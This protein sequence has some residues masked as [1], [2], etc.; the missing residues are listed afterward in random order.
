MCIYP[1]IYRCKYCGYTMQFES[2]YKYDI[3]KDMDFNTAPDIEL[4]LCHTPDWEELTPEE[5][6]HGKDR[7]DETH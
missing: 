7:L 3:L 4:F 6:G 1:I 2:P 5:Y